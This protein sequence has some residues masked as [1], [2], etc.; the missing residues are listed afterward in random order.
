MSVD[1]PVWDRGWRWDLAQIAEELLKL[2]GILLWFAY[3]ARVGFLGVRG[4]MQRAA[5]SATPVGRP[6]EAMTRRPNHC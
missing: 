2:N 4:A 1:V 3:L 5:P 6:P